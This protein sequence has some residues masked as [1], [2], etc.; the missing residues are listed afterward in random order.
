MIVEPNDADTVTRLFE[1]CPV[2]L[3]TR[4][5]LPLLP[6]HE[7]EQQGYNH[8]IDSEGN[9]DVLGALFNVPTSLRVGVTRV[10][11]VYPRKERRP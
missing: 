10:I 3:L 5:Q 9:E 11:F 6:P 8:C 4:S 2:T 1:E 7:A